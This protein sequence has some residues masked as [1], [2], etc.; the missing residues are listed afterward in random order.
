[1]VILL[2]NITSCHGNT[3]FRSDKVSK[4]YVNFLPKQVICQRLR[5]KTLEKKKIWVKQVFGVKSIFKI[6]VFSLNPCHVTRF[7]RKT[8]ML[9]RF[10]SFRRGGVTLTRSDVLKS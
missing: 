10:Y 7:C 8:N 9:G 3:P 1:M 2:G 5:L 4:K 6:R